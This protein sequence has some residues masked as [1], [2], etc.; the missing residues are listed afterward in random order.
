MRVS[1]GRRESTLDGAWGAHHL[2]T[3][4]ICFFASMAFSGCSDERP[5]TVGGAGASE[6]TTDDEPPDRRPSVV[7]LGD[8]LTI[9]YGLDP[10][11]AYP[12]LLQERADAAGLEFRIVNAG[13]TGETT[14][15]GLRRLD[16]LLKQD[17]AV[18]VLALGGN[19]GLR[20]I[21]VATVEANLQAMIDRTREL[22]PEARVILA[23]MEAPPS[24]GDVFTAPFRAIFPR[25]AARNDVPLIPFLLEGVGG[26]P[27]F[28]QADGIHPNAE[29]QVRVAENVWRV[30]EPVLRALDQ[31]RGP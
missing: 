30:L 26:E 7:F 8:S 18:L 27:E 29:G 2:F 3:V 31:Q 23:G 22:R 10:D 20:G 6:S 1:D 12:A 28:N 21:D 19:D 16:W 25:V 14:S 17:V 15:G 11:Q 5:S 13:V 9:G 24:M 4:V